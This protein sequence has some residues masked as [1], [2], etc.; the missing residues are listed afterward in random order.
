V[1]SPFATDLERRDPSD[2]DPGPSPTLERERVGEHDE[3]SR[4]ADT[5]A[6]PWRWVCSLDVTWPDGEFGRGSG[7]LVGPR[8]VLTAAHCIYR[9]R[10]AAGPASVYVAPARAGRTDPIG[11]FKAVAYSVSGAYLRDRMIGRTLI[12]APQ[13]RSR[14]DFAIVTLDRN[15]ADVVYDRPKD[16]RPFGHWGHVH[17][18][19]FTRLRGLDGGFL[20][21]KPVTVAGYPGDWCGTVR[22]GA[23]PC[24]RQKDLATVQFAGPGT[25]TIDARQPG[26]LLHTVDTHEGQSGSPVWMRFRDGTRYLVGV[27]VGVGT[28]DA[29]TGRAVNNRAVHLSPEV[30]TLIRSWMPGVGS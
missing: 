19:S 27:H 5:W 12:R 18:G 24:D 26:L 14:F 1:A 21:G 22:V 2:G 25:V 3:R 7:T 30:V 10:D 20:A 13:V 11:R 9:S 23:G 8:Q 6:P 15:V 17:E 16:P 29:T 4:V 28:L